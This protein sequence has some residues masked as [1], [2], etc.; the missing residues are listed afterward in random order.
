V[1]H[2]RRRALPVAMEVRL[3]CG[4]GAVLHPGSPAPAAGLA[5][6]LSRLSVVGGLASSFRATRDMLTP[7]QTYARTR[8]SPT[9]SMRSRS[10]GR[11]C[12]NPTC[13]GP[14]TPTPPGSS[15]C[16]STTTRTSSPPA[17]DCR[18]GC[19]GTFTSW[20]GGPRLDSPS[21][22][23]RVH[24]GSP[25]C[26]RGGDP[27]RARR[28]ASRPGGSR[29]PAGAPTRAS[30]QRHANRL[31]SAVKSPGPSSSR[32]LSALPDSVRRPDPA[33]GCASRAGHR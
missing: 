12:A 16:W 17:P 15:S 31:R 10:P 9:R 6:I 7:R 1:D 5:S 24:S 23:D 33:S 32:G 14:S 25:S 27:D 2:L 4:G 29:R 13:P 28:A 19:A 21:E 3:R 22:L 20:T 11:R 8:A 26:R 30:S 18:T